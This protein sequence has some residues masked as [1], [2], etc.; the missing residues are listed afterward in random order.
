MNY[1]NISSQF[2]FGIA[3][4]NIDYLEQHAHIGTAN[5]IKGGLTLDINDSNS[6]NFETRKNFETSSTEYINLNYQYLN[7]C[8][9]ARIEFKRDFYSDQDIEP[10]DT[11]R[12]TFAILPYYQ[13]ATGDLSGLDSGIQRTFDDVRGK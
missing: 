8:F 9:R 5:Y 13:F 11:I 2:K 3:S 4:L 6:L 10:T 12:L 7:D 1:N